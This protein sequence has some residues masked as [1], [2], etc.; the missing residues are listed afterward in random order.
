MNY[1]LNLPDESPLK[2]NMR[3]DVMYWDTDERARTANTARDL[4]ETGVKTVGDAYGGGV[5]EWTNEVL[6]Q[7]L[8]AGQSPN[9][10]G[11]VD[12]NI[13]KDETGTPP[14]TT[15]KTIIIS[16]ANMPDDD[17]RITVVM[18]APQN[19]VQ[20][21]PTGEYNIIVLAQ[22][23]I[24]TTVEQI[25]VAQTQLQEIMAKMLAMQGN[26]IVINELKAEPETVF[27]GEL[28]RVNI[29][30]VST[31][32]QNLTF[33]WTVTGGTYENKSST[34]TG[35]VFKPTQEGTFTVTCR[36]ED[37]LGN[38]K[39]K[40]VQ[41]RVIN[42]R[43]NVTFDSIVNENFWDE[44][45]NPGEIATIAL[46]IQNN[47]QIAISG[48]Q[49]VTGT[50]GI[51]VNTTPVGATLSA[52]ETE[53]WQVQ[54]QIPKLFS[55]ATGQVIYSIDAFDQN[56]NPVTI[57][58]PIEFPVDF[59]VEI[60]PIQTG[61]EPITDRVINVSG[62]VAN[63]QLTTAIMF[64]DGEYDTPITLNLSNGSFNQQIALS[65]SAAPVLHTVDVYAFSGSLEGYDT[66]NFT[67][68]VPITALRLTLT[69]DTNNTD[70]DFWCTD[71]N[72]E[73]CVYYHT[74]TASGLE[75]DFDDT[76]GYG[77][78]NITTTNII[79]G[80]YLVQVHYY[81]DHDWENAI[82]SN[83]QV[84]IR[85]NEGQANETVNFYYGG[86]SDTGDVWTVTTLHYDGA[87]WTQK[88]VNKHSKVDPKTLPPK[89]K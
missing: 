56:N 9:D 74:Q 3:R 87:K 68:H 12:L 4:G 16:K 62:K 72:G 40:S 20:Q 18:N 32:G 54:I 64:L 29:S 85:Q 84:V 47:S 45:L 73:K 69:W 66:E 81:S 53:T 7:H 48:L 63:P 80:D 65:G 67:S 13:N 39:E 10:K 23:Y 41:V 34:A 55:E 77:P 24:R 2:M 42:T 5:G 60:N 75:L 49:R 46:N 79:P 59:Y 88:A 28:S 50:G 21:L 70:V 58:A 17:P 11:T 25:N 57:S 30:C 61:T 22:D 33:S 31:I 43:I 44:K 89:K 82:Y 6:N 37:A 15:P 14:I 78:E 36:V 51:I 86:L 71:P 1:Y 83:C 52:N 76:N 26:A 8:N 27:L 38:F 35:L 19:L